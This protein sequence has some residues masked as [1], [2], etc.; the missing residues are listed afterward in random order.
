MKV[1]RKFDYDATETTLVDYEVKDR[2]GR[3]IGAEIRFLPCE[4]VALPDDAPSYWR[5]PAVGQYFAASFN[6]TRDG[7]RYGAS[8]R[9]KLFATAAERDA[10]RDKYL[11]DA[12]KRAAKTAAKVA[13]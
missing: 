6:A 11:A 7:V 2:L 1:Q 13:A 8:Q 5:G 10:A 9:Q 12:R 3:R 4:V